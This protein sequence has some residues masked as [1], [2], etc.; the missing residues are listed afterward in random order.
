MNAFHPLRLLSALLVSASAAQAQQTI[1]VDTASDVLDFAGAQTIAEL[2]GPDGKISLVEAGLASDNTPGVQTIGFHVPQSEWTYQ[3]LYPGR[4]VLQPFLGF[5]AFDTVILDAT[6]QTAFTGDTNPA[7]GEVVIW[8]STYLV[9]NVGGVIQGF[10]STAISISGG[11]A[12][13]VRA[14]TNCGVEVYDSPFTVVGGSQPGDGNTGF[15][16]KIDRS[17]DNVVI[18][19]TVQRVRVLGWI[20]GGQP[21]ANVRVGG[22][23]LGERNY[24]TGYGT[25]SEGCP[26]GNAV[27]IFDSIGAVI[28]NNW[29]GT[30]PDGMA[31]GHAATTA[32]IAVD[33]ENYGLT[34]RNNRIAGVQAH[35]TYPHCA[36][37]IS[38]IGILVGG[39][40]NGVTIRGNTIG[41]DA[42][43]APVLGSVTGISLLNYYLGPVQNVVIGGTGPGEGNE[44]AGNLSDGISVAN[45]HTGAVISGNSI[46]DNGAL[47]IDLITPG[48]L[49]G[50]TPNDPLDVDTGGNG[51]QNFPVIQSVASSAT[52]L[53]VVGTLNS[54]ASASFVLEFFASPQADASGFGEGELYLGSTNVSTNASGNASFDVTLP[55]SVPSTWHVSATARNTASGSTSE[56]AASVALGNCGA[57]TYCTAKTNSQGCAP[58]ISSTGTPS[59]SAGSGFVVHG[60]AVL[61]NKP[62]LLF[63]GIHG[64]SG[65]PFQGGILCVA[66]PIKRTPLVNSGGT[67]PP[68]TD[69]SGHLSIDMNAFAVGS[70]GGTPLPEL[71]VPGTVVHTQWWSRDPGFTPP[72]NTSLSNGLSYTICN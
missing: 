5:R 16:I 36:G 70:L 41:L 13:V 53:R 40:G 67:P 71:T 26:G 68:A 57:T 31:Q 43:G 55:V 63:Y 28:E 29:I 42:S 50:V 21:A 25:F 3:W 22:P 33:Y 51:L 24:I 7:G 34:I 52:T 30:T 69:C 54:N 65:A 44:V 14:N 32:G 8:A 56:F 48:F 2:P 11:S 18:G 27:E 10:D 23:T 61:N 45:T 20:A 15:S 39:T 66:A 4:V 19:N 59:S 9:D 60:W 46:H 72:N 38:G 17:H 62:A 12:N 47:G 37:S 49:H 64:P 58:S 1:F 6:T 35:G